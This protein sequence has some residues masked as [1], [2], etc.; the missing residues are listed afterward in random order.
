M[1]TSLAKTA[2]RG[3]GGYRSGRRAGIATPVTRPHGAPFVQRKSACA[4]GGRCPSC[5]SRLPGRTAHEREADRVA[6]RVLA[7]PDPSHRP[8]GTAPASRAAAPSDRLPDNQAKQAAPSHSETG[9]LGAA[10]GGL[11]AGHGQPLPSGERKFFEPRFGRSFAG[12]RIHSGAAATASARRLSAKAFTLGRD[13]VF[14]AGQYAPGSTEGRRLIAHELTHVVQ[15]DGRGATIQ[16]EDD[17][18]AWVQ[19]RDGNL[20]YKTR[21]EAEHRRRALDEKGEWD[22]YRV[23]DFEL[24]GKTR[25]RVEMRGRKSPQTPAPPE[26]APKDEARQPRED[27]EP[28]TPT[29]KPSEST[30]PTEKPDEPAPASKKIC[31]TFDDGPQAPG[32]EEVLD[33]LKAKGAPGAFFLTGKNLKSNAPKQLALVERMLNE[34]HQI[35]NHTFTHVPA[36]RADYKKIYGDLSNAGKKRLFA[37]NYAKNRTYF[38]S[39]FKAAGATFPDFVLARLPGDGRF[40]K[41][42]G[43][44]VYVQETQRLGLV[45]VTW[46]YEYAPNK[47]FKHVKIDNWK[48]VMGVASEFKGYP[49]NSHII[50]FHD[51][52]WGGGNKTKFGN[53]IT[54]LTSRGFSFGKIGSS[55][56]CA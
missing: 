20:Y 40:I 54:H 10:N 18:E 31:L 24:K 47:V 7:M 36:A 2:R 37:E 44:V 32:T 25:W 6:E 1:R 28:A 34:G 5:Q 17:D 13:V 9:R 49:R 21:E 52:H 12:V 53:L 23:T 33:T 15:Q 4:C 56:K 8:P 30:T 55:G 48:G 46:H 16:R 50:L 39:L 35:A 38:D 42:N 41:F 11:V 43:V 26:S 14:G 51:R 45:H 27:T 22:E 29:E 3:A 19:D